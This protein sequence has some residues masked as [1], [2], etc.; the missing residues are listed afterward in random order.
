MLV[1]PAAARKSEWRKHRRVRP[2]IPPPRRCR[3][4]IGTADKHAAIRSPLAPDPVPRASQPCVVLSR[5]S[6]PTGEAA[7][8]LAAERSPLT[9]QS[10]HDKQPPPT[11]DS[12]SVH[13]PSLH[14]VPGVSAEGP[15]GDIS[16]KTPIPGCTT[17]GGDNRSAHDSGSSTSSA[18]RAVFDHV[19]GG[20]RRN[21]IRGDGGAAVAAS[22]AAN[23]VIARY[24]MTDAD[25]ETST[26]PRRHRQPGSAGPAVPQLSMGRASVYVPVKRDLAADD[27]RTDEEVL[28]PTSDPV[29][30]S[31]AQRVRSTS[32]AEDCDAAGARRPTECLSMLKQM[33]RVPKLHHEAPDLSMFQIPKPVEKGKGKRVRKYSPVADGFVGSELSVPPKQKRAR[34]FQ[35]KGAPPAGGLTLVQGDLHV[36]G[37]AAQTEIGM[38][39][40]DSLHSLAAAP[41][42]RSGD[43]FDDGVTLLLDSAERNVWMPPSY[44]RRNGILSQR[45]DQGDHADR[46][47]SI[48]CH[49]R[50]M[51]PITQTS[52]RRNLF[53][54]MGFQLAKSTAPVR[55]GRGEEEEEMDGP[56]ETEGNE[57]GQ[58]SGDGSSSEAGSSSDSTAGDRPYVADAG[59]PLVERGDDNACEGNRETLKASE[60]ALNRVRSVSNHP[61]DE[62]V[63]TQRYASLWLRESQ[64]RKGLG[65]SAMDLTRPGQSARMQSSGM[66][67]EVQ[68]EIESTPPAKSRLPENPEGGEERMR[69]SISSTALIPGKRQPVAAAAAAA[70]V[71][72]PASSRQRTE[73]GTAEAYQQLRP[74]EHIP[75]GVS[76]A[77][78]NTFRSLVRTHRHPLT[79]APLARDTR[80][81]RLKSSIG[82]TSRM[83]VDEST[84]DYF[85]GTQQKLFAQDEEHMGAK[86][87]VGD[88]ISPVTDGNGVDQTTLSTQRHGSTNTPY[89]R[90]DQYSQRR[91]ANQGAVASIQPR[92]VVTDDVTGMG[93]LK[94]GGRLPSLLLDPPFLR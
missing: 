56:C 48:G 55:P 73:H 35:G 26:H 41:R 63:L 52:P 72:V 14:R 49:G 22:G 74:I 69:S 51:A 24:A 84:R 77:A 19:V 9:Q 47:V 1:S 20:A 93:T 21:K 44:P 11:S 30:D 80:P 67:M 87:L 70:A 42:E 34:R 60:P 13:Q 78:E 65:D 2:A 46:D 4:P 82:E 8:D 76:S 12:A 85:S 7:A 61:R 75:E 90:D 79:D 54:T 89:V 33:I 43:L 3:R 15:G 45:Q 16:A 37:H 5:S 40:M 36:L 32:P 29:E 53:P 10:T 25:G 50:L 59:Y 71:A 58:K 68:E 91:T 62:P 66:W 88:H 83:M 28:S 17:P 57:L 38:H 92:S 81:K 31:Q 27:H 86:Y 64:Y 23:V 18:Q 6:S 94:G 39:R